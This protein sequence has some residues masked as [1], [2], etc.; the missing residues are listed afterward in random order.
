LTQISLTN[1]FPEI[2]VKY[3]KRFE[4]NWPKMFIF[5]DHDGVPW[6]NKENGE[7]GVRDD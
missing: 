7:N 5:L 4:K 2:A 1:Y 3:K 6:N